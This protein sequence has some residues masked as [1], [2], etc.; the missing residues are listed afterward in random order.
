MKNVDIYKQ[1]FSAECTFNDV[2]RR[3]VTVWLT[4]ESDSGMIR[5]EVGISFFPH[6][7][8]NDFSISYDAC[9]LKELI[10][11]KGRRSKKRDEQYLAQVQAVANELASSLQGII[12]WNKPLTE[13]QYG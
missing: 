4:A 13:A 6:R 10:R 7:D 2:E 9:S 12:H 8:D 11:T 3:G 5:Y 1:Y